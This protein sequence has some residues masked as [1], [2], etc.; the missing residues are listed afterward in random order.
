MR[1]DA[2][3]H[4]AIELQYEAQHAMRRRMLRT[5]IH[6]E[7]ARGGCGIGHQRPRP[8]AAAALSASLALN[9]SQATI[10]R[11]C[12]P[13]PIRSKPSWA[14]TWKLARRPWT[15]VHSASTVTFN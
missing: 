9:R 1:I 3:D 15:P 8:T 10:A 13:S 2:L 11:S 14:R 4:L 12:R 7:G 5:E 6:G